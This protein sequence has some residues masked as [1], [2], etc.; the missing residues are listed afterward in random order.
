MKL[1]KIKPIFPDF[2]L[3]NFS[4]FDTITLLRLENVFDYDSWEEH[5]NL[6]LTMTAYGNYQILMEFVD[7]VCFRFQGNGQISGF[8]IKDMSV[9]GYENNS[10]YEVGD[11]EEG[12]IGFYC[13]DIVIKSFE[14]I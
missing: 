1:D 4:I 10:K 12:D 13:S 2:K 9:R 8:Y 7:V 5:K 3:E 14:K 11:Y 6:L